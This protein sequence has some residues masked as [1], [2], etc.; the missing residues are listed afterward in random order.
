[1]QHDQLSAVLPRHVCRQI[2]GLPGMLRAVDRRQDFLDHHTTSSSEVQW[3]IA[4]PHAVCLVEGMRTHS[5][6]RC[7]L[8][9]LPG[10]LTLTWLN[11]APGNAAA[12]P[13]WTVPSGDPKGHR[14]ATTVQLPAV[15]ERVGPVVREHRGPARPLPA[16]QLMPSNLWSRRRLLKP[17][18]TRSV[19]FQRSPASSPPRPG[20]RR[21][22]KAPFAPHP[23][24]LKLRLT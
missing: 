17:S 18:T 12:R 20:G 4:A 14:Q 1:M 15:I 2:Q 16:S 21:D 8:S 11:A 23:R 24:R 5:S 6:L 3:P 9:W 10:P 7:G 19:S 22:P 13:W